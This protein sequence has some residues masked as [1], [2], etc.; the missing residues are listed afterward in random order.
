MLDH[1]FNIITYLFTYF[2]LPIF[3]DTVYT[4]LRLEYV[5]TKSEVKIGLTTKII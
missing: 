5:S 3:Y 4:F 2:Y 1:L